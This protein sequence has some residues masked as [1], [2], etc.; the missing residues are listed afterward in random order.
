M[1]KRQRRRSIILFLTWYATMLLVMA[2]LSLWPYMP[3]IPEFNR[4][5]W[6]FVVGFQTNIGSGKIIGR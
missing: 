1:T 4:E 2:A 6:R 5:D 3:F